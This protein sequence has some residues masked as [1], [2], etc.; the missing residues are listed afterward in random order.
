MP[1]PGHR[2]HPSAPSVPEQ[3]LD[4]FRNAAVAVVSDNMNRMHGTRALKPYHP[5]GRLI[6][7]AV[8]VKTRPTAQNC[9]VTTGSGSGLMANVTTVAVTCG[10]LPQYAYVVNNGDNTVSQ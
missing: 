4:G 7:T 1:I 2:F 9:T 10:N 3:V 6:G 8:T 5:G